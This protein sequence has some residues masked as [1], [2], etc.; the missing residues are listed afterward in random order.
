MTTSTRPFWLAG[1][2]LLAGLLIY[3]LQ[4]IL[5]PFLVAAL[6]AYL[7][8]PVTDRLEA[9]GLG[10]TTAV[11]VVFTALSLTVLLVLLLLL[12][13]LGEQLR[14]LQ[15]RLPLILDWLQSTALPWLQARLSLDPELF[16][17]ERLRGIVLENPGQTSDVLGLITS[18]LT[19]SGLALAAWL[20]NL[21]L[22]PVVTFYLLRD[23]DLLMARL[24][25]LLPSR[26][27]DT[28]LKLAR[29]CDEVLSAFLRGQLLVMAAL[30]L[31]YSSGLWLLGLELALLIGVIAGLVNIVPYL[32]FIVGIIAATVA[33]WFQFG[34][35][36]QLFAVWGVFLLGQVLEGSVL[37]PLLVGDRIGLHPVA[38]IFAVLAGGELFG[39]VGI[40]L[41]LPVAAVLMVLL[42]HTHALYLRSDLYGGGE[43]S[44]D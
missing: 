33:A 22:I 35:A 43:E 2:L 17:F 32:G 8:D 20:A 9:W 26:A 11:L 44:R 5:T 38:V 7:G 14:Y 12:P 27:Q 19:S 10:R 15:S 24:R 4:P 13:L 29:E 30:A 42:R 3:L 36:W 1:G 6:F 21:A 40:L 16:Q 31:L 39:F 23:W 34:A 28:T 18:R 25:A 37:T 41:A